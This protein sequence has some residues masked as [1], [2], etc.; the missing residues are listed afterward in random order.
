MNQQPPI[1]PP[2]H[3][4]FSGS[5]ACS[6]CNPCPECHAYVQEQV[7]PSA[8][9]ASRMNETLMTLH[10]VIGTLLERGVD[11]VRQ[12]GLDLSRVF[13]TLEAQAEAFF[14][15]LNEGWG[16]MHEGMRTN[17][18]TRSRLVASPVYPEQQG[19]PSVQPI[20]AQHPAGEGTA[21]LNPQTL[22]KAD[23][24]AVQDPW[25]AAL[26]EQQRKWDE[27]DAQEVQTAP[28]S[29]KPVP[30]TVEEVASMGFPLDNGIRNGA[31]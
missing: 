8:F 24:A 1:P 21:M 4:C 13:P 6:G 27:E 26:E 22:L 28:V 15:G 18:A 31:S 25:K 30:I 5:P 3:V 12:M 20:S 29:P 19:L 17:P 16:R 2:Q 14:V 9:I 23:Q 11:P 10:T 7:L